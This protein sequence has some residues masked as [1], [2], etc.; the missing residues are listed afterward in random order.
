VAKA[1][2]MFRGHYQPHIPADLGFYD[3][4]VAETRDAQAEMAREHGIEGFCYWHYWFAGKRLIEKPFNEVVKSKK[5][6]FPFCVGWANQSWTGIWHGAQDKMLMEQTYP[7]MADYKSHFYSL[8]DAFGDDRYIT[9]EGK[10][11]FV[12]YNPLG[13]PDPKIFTGH[14][15]N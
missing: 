3:L 14:I 15:E 11:V 4:R 8:L 10:P 6:D 1:K 2:P 12:I 13:L 9:V 7:G 5:P